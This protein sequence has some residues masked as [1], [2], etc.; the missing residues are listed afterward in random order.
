[1]LEDNTAICTRG[2]PRVAT[3]ESGALRSRWPI[4]PPRSTV[5]TVDFLT[6]SASLRIDDSHRAELHRQ[7]LEYVESPELAYPSASHL[8]RTRQA[9]LLRM[10]SGRIPMLAEVPPAFA[11]GWLPSICYHRHRLETTLREFQNCFISQRARGTR[12][13]RQG[14]V[15][16]V[17]IL[18]SPLHYYHYYSHYYYP[19][20]PVKSVG[21]MSHHVRPGWLSCCA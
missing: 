13:G 3:I 18:Y 21:V 20:L 15:C 1:V 19:L 12:N 9:R 10:T 14:R 5:A 17:F 11:H 8:L 2:I 7:S 6:L 16:C 4:R